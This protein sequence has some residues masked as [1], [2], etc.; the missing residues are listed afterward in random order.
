MSRKVIRYDRNPFQNNGVPHK[1]TYNKDRMVQ[2]IYFR[3]IGYNIQ[4]L[5]HFSSKNSEYD[6]EIPRLQTA[7]K[8]LASWEIATKQSRNTRKINRARERSDSVVE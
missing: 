7:D 2:S 5:L 4:T 1:A 8:P 3:V 6:L